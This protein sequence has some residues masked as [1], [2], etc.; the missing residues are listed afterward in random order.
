[1]EQDRNITQVNYTYYIHMEHKKTEDGSEDEI[2][3]V[4]RIMLS[5]SANAD[6]YMAT[7]SM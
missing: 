7:I 3:A 6:L 2:S 4:K 5:I 1:M